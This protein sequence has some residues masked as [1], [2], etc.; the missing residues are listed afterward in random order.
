MNQS[1]SQEIR[2]SNSGLNKKLLQ[3]WALGK[4]VAWKATQILDAENL[5]E[6]KFIRCE[7]SNQKPAWWGK[8]IKFVDIPEIAIQKAIKSWSVG[9]WTRAIVSDGSGIWDRDTVRIESYNPNTHEFHVIW[10]HSGRFTLKIP[11][12]YTHYDNTKQY[13][14]LGN[15]LRPNPTQPKYESI[16]GQLNTFLENTK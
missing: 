1:K 14:D 6:W 16:L 3:S 9:T 10:Q 13:F 5:K 8:D 4:M 7:V 15:N 11:V 12:S 2:N